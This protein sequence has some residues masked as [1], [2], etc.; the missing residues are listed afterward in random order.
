ML[1]PGSAPLG[2]A[3][4][5]LTHKVC[6]AVSRT[7]PTGKASTAIIQSLRPI[8]FL[9]CRSCSLV[10]PPFV[11]RL[12]TSMRTHTPKN[13]AWITWG[14]TAANEHVNLGPGS[15]ASCTEPQQHGII[16]CSFHL[17]TRRLATGLSIL[18]H[19]SRVRPSD[20]NGLRHGRQ[21]K[22]ARR[23]SDLSRLR[24]ETVSPLSLCGSI[25]CHPVGRVRD[26]EP[27]SLGTKVGSDAPRRLHST[28]TDDECV[29]SS[30][31]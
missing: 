18:N 10:A 1:K 2:R 31:S 6:F 24:T 16:C 3:G 9:S 27:E 30:T 28:P 20:G 15:S 7:A 11:S 4:L 5:K 21:L 23:G 19:F 22:E 13:T 25:R 26:R 12:D 14:D 8:S 17:L 29:S